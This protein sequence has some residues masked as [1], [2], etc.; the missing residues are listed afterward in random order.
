MDHPKRSL[1]KS[2][3]WRFFCFLLTI[4]IVY[5]YTKKIKQ[6]IGAGVVIDGI[7]MVLYY[8]HERLWNKSNFGRKPEN[9]YQI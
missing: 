2:I 5:I 7:K 3:S 4:A 8:I 1:A 9:D 6:A